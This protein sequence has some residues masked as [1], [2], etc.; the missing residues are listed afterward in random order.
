MGLTY[1]AA[2]YYSLSVGHA[3][4]DA[5]GAFEALIGFGYFAG[6]LIGLAARAAATPAHATSATVGLAWLV[7]AGCGGRAR[8]LSG[9]PPRAPALTAVNAGGGRRARR[10]GGGR[11]SRE[12]PGGS[13]RSSA[14]PACVR[15]NARARRR[16]DRRRGRREASTPSARSCRRI[17]DALCLGQ[18][19]PPF[20]VE[21][22]RHEP[23]LIDQP[24]AAAC[25]GSPG[26]AASP[27]AP[28][29]QARALAKSAAGTNVEVVAEETAE[30]VEVLA[31][32]P[33]RRR[34]GE[35]RWVTAGSMPPPPW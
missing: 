26:R 13:T 11:R 8:A 5:G 33:R 3:A 16:R 29:A 19:P 4:V 28:A 1:Y 34:S 15:G 25:G 17:E 24:L 14:A 30:A 32:R 2:L 23:A 21:A 31:C 22:G 18:P 12:C 35:A 27:S 20:R 9:R 10:R 7:A 6:P